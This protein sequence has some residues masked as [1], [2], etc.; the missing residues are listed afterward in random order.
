M[1]HYQ[2]HPVFDDE[3]IDVELMD[4]L[5]EENEELNNFKVSQ[6]ALTQLAISKLWSFSQGGPEDDP[7]HEFE[8]GQQFDNKEEAV[9]A[10]KIYSIK[11]VVEYKI[12]E[13]DQLKYDVHC[14]HVG[15]GCQWNIRIAYRRKQEKW[16]V[17]RYSRSYYQHKSF[18]RS[19]AVENHFGYK[20]SY[21]KVWLV[22][23]R[24]IAK[25]CNDW[26][27]SYNELPRWLFAMQMYLS[28]KIDCI[29]FSTSLVDLAIAQD[30]NSNI[31]P[32][33]FAV[34]EEKTKEVWSFFLSNL[35]KEQVT[36]QPG[37]LVI[38]DRYESIDIA[39]NANGSWW[40]PLNAYQE[41]CT[42]Y[43]AANF[44]IH[45]KNKNLKKVLVNT[46][47]LKSRQ[48]F[49]HYFDRLRGENV[50][51]TNWLKE[52]PR[53]QRAQYS[54]EGR[55]FGDMTTNISECMNAVMKA[56]RNLSITALVKSTYFRL[57][58]LF[59]RKRT[60]AQAQVQ[61]GDE[62]SQTFVKTIEFNSKHVNTMNVYQFNRLRTIF[63]VEELTAVCTRI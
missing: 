29:A 61:V 21:R 57:G 9:M 27:A 3:D 40:K 32:I 47:Y 45:F 19:R 49:G 56:I 22:K 41:F 48:E 17:R 6:V 10:V 62:F 18:P 28:N 50:T 5:E 30:S 60:E 63:T 53:E 12:L 38:L 16:E 58:E 43:I 59:A 26:E 34:V 54:D 51:I 39:L 13:S 25:I 1:D 52:I 37:L 8:I 42:R 4:I 11:R 35:L 20:T 7:T 23:Q 31:L 15:L 33:I 36:P 24:V 2:A 55:M 46:T 44:M 14:T